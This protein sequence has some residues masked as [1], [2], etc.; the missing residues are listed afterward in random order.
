MMLLA[1]QLHLSSLLHVE[2][3]RSQYLC[4]FSVAFSYAN[5]LFAY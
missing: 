5:H 4:A 1:A 3:L 2:S